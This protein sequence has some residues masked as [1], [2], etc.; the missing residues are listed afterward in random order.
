MSSRLYARFCKSSR[1]GVS[2]SKLG[3]YTTESLAL[4]D[5]SNNKESSII[6]QKILWAS[7]CAKTNKESRQSSP[8]K[9]VKVCVSLIVIFVDA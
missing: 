7:I 1:L 6:H 5:Q 8:E 2:T 4:R 9:F 3:G